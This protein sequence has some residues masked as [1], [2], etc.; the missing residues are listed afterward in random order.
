M[1]VCESGPPPQIL[2]TPPPHMIYGPKPHVLCG[3]PPQSTRR[4]KRLL[5]L[6]PALYCEYIFCRGLEEFLPSNTI[7]QRV[8]LNLLIVYLIDF[9]N[10]TKPPT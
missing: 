1:C 4:F 7:M 5:I 6:R 10:P 3:P 9:K 2:H 8:G